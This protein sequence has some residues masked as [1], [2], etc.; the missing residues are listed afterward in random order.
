[1]ETAL[2]P[3]VPAPSALLTA[4]PALLAATLALLATP[5]IARADLQVVAT[6][7]DLAAI[8]REIGGEHVTVTALAPPSQDP[9]YV[10]PRPNLIL[11]LNRADLL[12]VNGLELEVGW[13]PPLQVAARNG[14]IQTGGEGYFD[15][16]AVVRRLGVPQSKVDRAM[17]DIHPGGN[18]HFLLD[19][20]AARQI[21]AAL[22]NRM[23]KLDPSNSAAYRANASAFDEALATFARAQQA[24]FAA[25]SAEQRRVVAYHASLVYLFDWLGLI[26]AET[27]EPRPGIAPTPAHVARVLSLMKQ[28]GIRVVVQEA[29]YPQKTSQTLTRL[30]GGRVVVL[31]GGTPDGKRYLQH[32]QGIAD[33]LHAALTQ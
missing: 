3:L 28:Q 25:L 22:A 16:S 29:Y 27:V 31:P 17:G 26:E 21:A 11:P 30:V 15:A 1:M 5:N 20:R 18:P 10:D 33:A 7:P 9:H 2:R 4:L 32:L 12:V 8:A 13:L 14:R 24:R 6:L 23:V 19:P